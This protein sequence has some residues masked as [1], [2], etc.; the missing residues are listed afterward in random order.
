M[1]LIKCSVC[2]KKMADNAKICPNCGAPN[3]VLKTKR[4]SQYTKITIGVVIILAL[5]IVFF[6]TKNMKPARM[7]IAVYDLGISALNVTD[8][9]LDSKID[10]DIANGKLDNI[11]N[12]LDKID[13]IDALL[14]KVQVTSISIDINRIDSMFSDSTMN[15]VL[16]GRNQLADKLNQNKR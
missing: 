12:K 16:E 15:D 7:E 4:K 2:S 11:S 9:F 6:A 14:I 13:D 10:A 5:V 8:E 1:S 3:Q